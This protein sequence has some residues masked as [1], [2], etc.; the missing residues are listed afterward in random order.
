MVELHNTLMG[1][2]FYEADIPRIAKALERIAI[3]LE[4]QEITEEMRQLEDSID[5]EWENDVR[6]GR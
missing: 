3:A 4:K 6:R 1:R 2:K 5:P